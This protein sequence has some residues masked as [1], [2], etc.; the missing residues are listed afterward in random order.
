MICMCIFFKKKLAYCWHYDGDGDG[1]DDRGNDDDTDVN[2]IKYQMPS[3][4]VFISYLDLLV[5]FCC[6]FRR[7]RKW[8]FLRTIRKI[9]VWCA[10]HWAR[11]SATINEGYA[12]TLTHTFLFFLYLSVSFHFCVNSFCRLTAVRIMALYVCDTYEW[13]SKFFAE[14]RTNKV[15]LSKLILVAF[16]SIDTRNHS[17]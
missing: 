9:N 1:N 14:K 16:V 12:N 2:E 4:I 6:W 13:K 10:H 11:W 3:V 5:F 17:R 8:I 7:W 15:G